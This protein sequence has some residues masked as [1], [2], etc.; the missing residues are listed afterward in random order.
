MVLSR[1]YLEFKHTCA[2]LYTVDEYTCMKVLKNSSNQFSLS[3][4]MS[5]ALNIAQ[6]QDVYPMDFYANDSLGPWTVNNVKHQPPRKQ[7]P[8]KTVPIKTET[9]ES[10]SCSKSCASCSCSQKSNINNIEIKEIT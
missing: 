2:Y 9:Q 3:L 5:V 7:R 1:E 6:W 4:Q 10:G 8:R